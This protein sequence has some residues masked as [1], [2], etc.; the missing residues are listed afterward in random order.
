MKN[1][2]ILW[3]MLGQYFKGKFSWKMENSE[4][5]LF[6][7]KA[8]WHEIYFIFKAY[9]VECNPF[10]N[11]LELFKI[12]Y[13]FNLPKFTTCKRT[14]SIRIL[15]IQDLWKLRNQENL[16]TGWRHSLVLGISSRNKNLVLLS[17]SIQQILKFSSPG[18]FCSISLMYFKY[19]VKNC[20]QRAWTSVISFQEVN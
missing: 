5:R 16:K 4:Q 18:E 13:M 2:Y 15:K 11:I 3:S 10:H 6:E 20:G 9:Q 1:I 12:Q 17:K 8:H 14:L 7:I 19:F